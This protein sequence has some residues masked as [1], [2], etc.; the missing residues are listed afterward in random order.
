MTFL[1]TLNTKV[2]A[3]ELSFPLVM[4][5]VLSDEWFDGYEL[6]KTEHDA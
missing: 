6:L 2:I 1:E 4:H 5:T 3:N